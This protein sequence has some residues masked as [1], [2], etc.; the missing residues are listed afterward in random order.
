MVD[1]N[2]TISLVEILDLEVKI[3]VVDIGASPSGGEP[4]YQPLIDNNCASIVGFEPD[5][6]ALDLLNANKKSTDIY[7]PY[8]VGDGGMHEFKH[9]A[10]PEM[11]SLLEPNL[12]LLDFFH[13]FSDF[14]RVVKRQN[15]TTKKLD[16]IRE[17]KNI[18][19]LKIDIQGGE[20]IVFENAIKRLRNCCVIHTEVE[21]IELYLNQPL[22]S[23]I[24]LFLRG[25]GFVF[26]KFIPL[27][28]RVLKPMLVENSKTAGLSQIFDGDA[29]FIR[30]FTKYDKT[31][32]DRLLKSA[33]ILHDLYQS[34]D[35][36]YQLLIAFDRRRRT[37]LAAKYLA[38]IA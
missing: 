26:H 13:L 19:L 21:F 3:D 12:K 35:M 28:S 34:L 2:S 10:A 38:K 17:I 20:L 11:S 37:N 33:I 14:A 15:V 16:E 5:Q 6:R 25:L 27:R 31:H 1:S 9:C 36:V 24:E 29:V 8:V 4:P 30:D 23:E 7:L 32:P 22:F 18:D